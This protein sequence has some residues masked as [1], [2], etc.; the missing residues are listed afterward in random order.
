MKNFNPEAQTELRV[1][2]TDLDGTLIP[3]EGNG[4]NREAL[5]KLRRA[6]R[7]GDFELIFVTGRHFDLVREA[8]EEHR[9]PEPDWIVC[10][11]GTSIY[12]KQNGDFSLFGPYRE[13]L[14][15]MT[16]NYDRGK[17][18]TL[19]SDLD[20]LE[21]Q[22]EENQREFK[23]SYECDEADTERLGEEIQRILEESDIPYHPTTSTDP[24][25]NSGLIDLLPSGASK[26]FALTWLSTHAGFH[27]DSVVFAGDSGNDLA[28]LI[29]GFHAIV[30]A[31]AAEGLAEMV[32]ADL[33]E[34]KLESQLYCASGKATSG[35]LEGCIHFGLIP[36][37]Y[38]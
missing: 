35:V 25:L 10:D 16:D 8:A 11:V 13:Q 30:V 19:L 7:D 6:R 12:R 9:L 24:F 20:G 2:A 4:E 37:K 5:E 34:K 17:V 33:Q 38:G 21:M 36:E 32:R 28:A 1:L 14:R 29:S 3:L 15:E 22:A 23:I 26:A 18:E 27:P 31:N